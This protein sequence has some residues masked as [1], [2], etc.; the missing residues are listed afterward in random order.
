[1]LPVLIQ[2]LR[3]Q[4]RNM[5]G[6]AKCATYWAAVTPPIVLFLLYFAVTSVIGTPFLLVKRAFVLV[7]NGTWSL[8]QRGAQRR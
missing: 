8:R 5:I 1:V 7:A 6:R 4:L 3:Y 2:A